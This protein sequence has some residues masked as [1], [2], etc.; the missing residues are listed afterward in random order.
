MNPTLLRR[1]LMWVA[2]I[3]IGFIVKK[4]EEKQNRK[5]QEKAMAQRVAP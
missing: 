2:P 3:A 4:Y 5:Q 1:I